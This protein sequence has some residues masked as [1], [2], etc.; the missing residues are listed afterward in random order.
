MS[1]GIYYQPES[2]AILLPVG[3]P[4]SW[5]AAMERAF[6]CGP[7]WLLTQ[8]DHPVLLGLAAGFDAED[9]RQACKTLALQ[10]RQHPIRV[11][12]DE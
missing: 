4:S 11:W 10:V 5:L 7:P 6:E 3:A 9:Q 8:E 2:G 1:V 12:V